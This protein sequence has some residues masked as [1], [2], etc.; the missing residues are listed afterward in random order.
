MVLEWTGADEEALARSVLRRR[1]LNAV[2]RAG[3]VT[4]AQ[5]RA[6]GVESRVPDSA[7]CDSRLL[8]GYLR[9]TDR[10]LPPRHQT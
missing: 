5:L 6:L 1:W 2:H 4:V 7:W 10:I 3:V 9:R 8:A